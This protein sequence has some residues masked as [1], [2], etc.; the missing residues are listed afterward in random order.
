MSQLLRAPADVGEP[1]TSTG[2]SRSS[3]DPVQ[4]WLEELNEGKAVPALH[5]L[6]V[7]L[8]GVA[9]RVGGGR[10]R[11]ETVEQFT[12]RCLGKSARTLLNEERTL[13]AISALTTAV[14]LQQW[15]EQHEPHCQIGPGGRFSDAPRWTQT[16]VGDQKFH[17]PLNLRAYF[18]AG[19]LLQQAGVIIFIDAQGDGTLFPPRVCVLVSPEH[20]QAANDLL[21]T[22]LELGHAINPYRG[23]TLRASSSSSRLC[24]KLIELPQTV[25]RASVIVPEDVWAEVDLAVRSVRDCHKVLN[26]WGLGSRR[27]VLL[28]GPPGTGK[29]AISA[30]IAQELAG[31]FTILYVEPKAGTQALSSIV[32]EAQQMGGP[33]MLVL[34]DVDLWVR[35][36]TS[37]GP[38]LAELLQ[39]MDI[40]PDARILTFA[41]TNDTAALDKAALRAGRFDSVIEIDYPTRADAARILTALIAGI[42]DPHAVDAQQVADALP[43]GSSGADI[44]ELVRRTIVSDTDGAITT[45]RLLAEVGAG[46]YRTPVSHG[47]Y[48]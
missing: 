6:G 32:E 21:E 31:E 4:A 10:D 11:A 30:V 42:A 20:Q 39:A 7:L 29:S 17:H 16:R 45:E 33:V 40:N 23:K 38:G 44:R 48:L 13:G 22:L 34:E 15:I 19:T 43:S 24:L 9:E 3:D 8:A 27:G 12:A 46:R 36:R 41:S 47:T 26:T 5:A 28:C 18:P 37:G 25:T 35:N 14:V 2:I 1:K